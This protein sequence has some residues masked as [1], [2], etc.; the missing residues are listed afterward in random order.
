M[1]LMFLLRRVPLGMLPVLCL[2]S[3]VALHG[4]DHTGGT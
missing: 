3:S 1:R 4:P 2:F